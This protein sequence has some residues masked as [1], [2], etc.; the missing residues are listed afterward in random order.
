MWYFRDMRQGVRS[1]VCQKGVG[2]GF[3]LQGLRF[4]ASVCASSVF[5]MCRLLGSHM[6]ECQN[7]GPFLGPYYNTGPTLG[8]PKRDHNLDNPPQAWLVI[9]IE[10]PGSVRKRTP[11]LK[12]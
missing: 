9:G 8:D 2:V 7:Y 3:R 1:R 5:L 12:A 11:K 6:G 4:E 10:N